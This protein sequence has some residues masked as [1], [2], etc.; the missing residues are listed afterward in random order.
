MLIG[1]PLSRIR[2][3]LVGAKDA[4]PQP[5]EQLVSRES[6]KHNVHIS[7]IIVAAVVVHFVFRRCVGRVWVSCHFRGI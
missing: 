1:F 2:E 6:H 7:V 4:Q 5:L 3:S